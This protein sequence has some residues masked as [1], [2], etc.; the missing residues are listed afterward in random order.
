MVTWCRCTS[1]AGD[2]RSAREVF[3]AMEARDVVSWNAMLTAYVRTADVVAAKE[4]FATMP[5]GEERHTMDDNDQGAVQRGGFHRHE[6]TV[7]PDA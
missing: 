5:A 1:K 3:D 4:L 6:G 7:Q 2:V